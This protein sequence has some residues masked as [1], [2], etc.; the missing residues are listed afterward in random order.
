MKVVVTG[1][2]GAGKTTVA[3]VIAR[4]MARSGAAVLA[5]DCDPNPNLGLS[6][7]L[8]EEVTK[9]LGAIVNAILEEK[10]VAPDPAPPMDRVAA[11]LT[12]LMVVAPDGVRL[13]QTGRIERPASGCLCCGSHFTT[14]QLLHQISLGRGVVVADLEPGINDLIWVDPE[15]EDVVVVVSEPYRKSLEV[16]SRTV[17]V[18]RDLG[19]ERVLVVANRLTGVHDAQLVRRVLPGVETVEVPED[20]S[21]ARAGALG[22]A[23]ADEAHDGP[24][25]AALRTFASDLLSG[26]DSPA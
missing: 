24:A 25:V 18:A 11:L 5:V 19:V 4:A 10:P 9:G 17:H 14:R 20:P 7:G 1:K 3:A 21:I 2:G 16:T 12:R 15:A 23:P 26:V 6:L 8:G 13:V 22:T